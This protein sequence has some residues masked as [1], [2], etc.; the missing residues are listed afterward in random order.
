MENRRT[1]TR[2]NSKEEKTQRKV[3]GVRESTSNHGLVKVTR[4][5]DKWWNLV[6][7]EVKPPFC[8]QICLNLR[9]WRLIYEF[10]RQAVA[11]NSD[12]L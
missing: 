9:Y 6:V 3:D 4:D 8:G 12:I 11:C 10:I 1:G 7:G 2:V 5:M